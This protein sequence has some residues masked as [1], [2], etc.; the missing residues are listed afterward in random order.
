M[1]F[2][3]SHRD[4]AGEV[5]VMQLNKRNRSTGA[6]GS[7]E[8]NRDL[9]GGVEDVDENLLAGFKFC[10]MTCQNVGQLFATRIMHR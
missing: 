2:L 7:D 4:F 6:D 8:G 10:G 1:G 5:G 3:D 9:I